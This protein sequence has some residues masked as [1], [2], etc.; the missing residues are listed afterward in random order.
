MTQATDLVYGSRMKKSKE[1]FNGSCNL[2]RCEQEVPDF[3]FFCNK[4][5]HFLTKE[6][7][8][9]IFKYWYCGDMDN[10]SFVL[11]FAKGLIDGKVSVR[12][13]SS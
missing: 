11:G 2:S 10:L 5:W 8:R 9:D 3:K 6:I 7:K 12:D 1:F 4:H 13:Y